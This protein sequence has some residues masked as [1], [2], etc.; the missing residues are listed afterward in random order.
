MK[1]EK[2]TIQIRPK[3]VKMLWHYLNAGVL[4]QKTF[5]Q[6]YNEHKDTGFYPEKLK[7]YQNWNEVDAL[8]DVHGLDPHDLDIPLNIG[9][10]KVTDVTPTSVMVGCQKVTYA[11]AQ[12]VIKLMEQA[13]R[14]LSEN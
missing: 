6:A 3:L 1:E 7:C 8:C 5:S 11:D 4:M 9:E 2:I 13:T 10:H 12:A 14:A